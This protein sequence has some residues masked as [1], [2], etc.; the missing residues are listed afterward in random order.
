MNLLIIGNTASIGWNLKKGLEKYYPDL[1]D[2]IDLTFKISPT[3]SGYPTKNILKPNEYD[4]VLYNYPFFKTYFRY[5][6]YINSNAILINYWHGTDARGKNFEN[7][8]VDLA[9]N[10]FHYF[11]KKFMVKKA[12]INLYSTFDLSWFLKTNNKQH[13]YQII[14]TDVFTD[15]NYSTRQGSIV[16]SKGAKGYESQRIDHEYM[17]KE[18][19][20]YKFARIFPAEGLD[21]HTIQV[22]HLE[23]LACGLIVEYHEE[24]NR[25]WVVKHCS[26]K[27]GADRFSQLVKALKSLLLNP[28]LLKGVLKNKKEGDL[29]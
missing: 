8:F 27:A 2:R 26:L 10:C 29:K 5:K 20:K 24:K 22:T 15:Y 6:E 11:F 18:L 12:E 4:I 9:Y 7:V 16:L 25:D 3:L 13:F 28:S 14:D 23:C 17:P 21:R 1:F 19:N